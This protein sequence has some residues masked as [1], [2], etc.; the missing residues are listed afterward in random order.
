[1][2]NF[3][4]YEVCRNYRVRVIR[5]TPLEGGFLLETNRGP[6]ELRIW[7]RIDV[8]RWSFAWRE[9]LARQGFRGLERFIRTREAKPFVIVGKQGVTMTDHLR[10]KQA[11]QPGADVSFQCG[12]VIAMMHKA[13]QESTL[14][15]GAEYLQ[16][17][18]RASEA[19][20]NRAKAAAGTYLRTFSRESGRRRWVGELLSPLLQRMERSVRLL[21]HPS[22]SPDAASVSHRDLTSDNWKMVNEK[23][24]L[25]GFFQPALSIQLRDVAGYLR[26]MYLTQADIRLVDSFLDGYEQE[27]PLGYG[28]YT[29][30]LAL[31]AR[32]REIWKSVAAFIDETAKGLRKSTREIE[33]AI[34]TQQAVDVLLRHIAERAEQVRG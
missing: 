33:Q 31:M 5:V 18:R 26:E 12:R 30:L 10:H 3:D 21:H 34:D 17:A 11:I 1:M 23:L 24:F 4:I 9:R 15:S 2:E 14:I 22:I 8:M 28:D 20:W 32:P 19:E 6:K 7:P 13:Q 27:K 25:T 29:L 16:Q